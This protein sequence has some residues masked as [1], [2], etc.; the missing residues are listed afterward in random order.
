MRQS[1]SVKEMIVDI[2]E[3][4]QEPVGDPCWAIS[5]ASN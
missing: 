5:R 2:E 1:S 3:E 4:E